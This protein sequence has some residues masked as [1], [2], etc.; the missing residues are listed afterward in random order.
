VIKD[1]NDVN[2]NRSKYKIVASKMIGIMIVD[3]EPIKVGDE[4]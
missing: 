1:K 4:W 2:P 3:S